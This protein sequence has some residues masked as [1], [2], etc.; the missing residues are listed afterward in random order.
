MSLDL[1]RLK[2]DSGS[3]SP[4]ERAELA[5]H[6][7]ESLDPTTDPDA[8]ARW[9]AE[10]ERRVGQIRRGEVEGIAADEVFAALKARR[11]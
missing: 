4:D 6:L 2:A 7:I 1:D 5:Y 11:S 9:E 3:L 10:V 8:E